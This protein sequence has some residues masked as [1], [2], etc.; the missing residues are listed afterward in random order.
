VTTANEGCIK[1][2]W[3]PS[4]RD[5]GQYKGDVLI[6]DYEPA[7]NVMPCNHLKSF[8]KEY[9]DYLSVQ[10]NVIYRKVSHKYNCIPSDRIFQFYNV[11]KTLK[12]YDTVII[13]DGNDIEFFKPI[14]P[15]IDY[16]KPCIRY[17]AETE[18]NSKLRSI[19]GH[20]YNVLLPEYYEAVKDKPIINAGVFG[21]PYDQIML[22]LSK[23]ID[24]F[25]YSSA[26]GSEQ[27]TLNYLVYSARIHA[28]PLDATWNYTMVDYRR[29]NYCFTDRPM[30]KEDGKD[31]EIAILHSNSYVPYIG[32]YNGNTRIRKV[33]GVLI[34]PFDERFVLHNS[35]WIFPPVY[36]VGTSA[37]VVQSTPRKKNPRLT[38]P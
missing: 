9:V 38:F 29:A 27:I 15:L 4:L 10:S 8:S 20:V 16:C 14:Q 36:N 18:K 23:M 37:K 12:G 22:L 35:K 2:I 24:N 1:N 7:I 3:L 21:G 30:G 11:L 6:V 31:I 33:D 28:L 26:F 5:D 19:F 13:T 34:N 25:E 32:K 17:V